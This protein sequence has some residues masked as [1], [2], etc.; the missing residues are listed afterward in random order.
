MYCCSSELYLVL[1]CIETLIEQVVGLKRVITGVF[2]SSE[3]FFC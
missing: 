2:E 3:L 1:L